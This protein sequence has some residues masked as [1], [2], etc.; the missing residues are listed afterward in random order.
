MLWRLWLLVVPDQPRDQGTRSPIELFCTDKNM[1]RAKGCYCIVLY[2]T[3]SWSPLKRET[4]QAASLIWF[5]VTSRTA[6]DKA[7]THVFVNI[8]Q[9]VIVSDLLL[10]KQPIIN[11]LWEY[12]RIW[13]YMCVNMWEYIRIYEN[14]WEYMERSRIYISGR[15]EAQFQHCALSCIA[16]RAQT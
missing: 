11:F 16:L 7:Q 8:L 3:T 13:E 5:I 12:V 6:L 14:M 9:C 4:R 1:F 15:A 10:H 2:R